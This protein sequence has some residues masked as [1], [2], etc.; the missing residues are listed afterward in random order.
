MLPSLC[1][2]CE[3]E[4]LNVTA[5]KMKSYEF[6]LSFSFQMLGFFFLWKAK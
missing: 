5:V 1:N 3:A 2:N 4:L 6:A